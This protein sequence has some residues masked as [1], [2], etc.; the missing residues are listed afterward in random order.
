ML[1]AAAKS[2]LRLMPHP[3]RERARKVY[4]WNAYSG[5]HTPAATSDGIATAVEVWRTLAFRYGFMRSL[6]EGRCVRADGS[7]IPWITY[8]A[9]EFLESLDF[10]SCRVFEYGAG[11]ST[12]FWA[13]RAAVVHSVEFDPDWYAR[14][15][16]SLPAHCSI[17]LARTITEYV[18]AIHRD[19]AGYDVVVV[20]GQNAEQGRLRGCAAALKVLRP[21]GMIVLDNSGNLPRSCAL[22]RD[23]GLIEVPMSGFSPLNAWSDTTSIFLRRDFAIPRREP[24]RQ[25]WAVGAPRN[26]WEGED[27][28]IIVDAP[29]EEAPLG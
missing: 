28:E 3:V 26:V 17:S 14:V 21:G 29:I 1:R 25:R 27:H 16:A 22:L 4:L 8:P 6:R 13:A 12:L 11:N 9:I 23:A 15:A 18:D 24:G 5:I 7:P 20:D 10:A 2:V 19:P